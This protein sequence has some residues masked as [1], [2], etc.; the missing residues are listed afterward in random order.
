VTPTNVRPTNPARRFAWAAAWLFVA[1]VSGAALVLL[2]Q[3]VVNFDMYGQ[4]SEGVIATLPVIA[5]AATVVLTV[6]AIR[7]IPAWRRYRSS[8]TV[9]GPAESGLA[10]KG[11]VPFMIAGVVTGLLSVAGVSLLV[12][13]LTTS[14]P[15]A[16]GILLLVAWISLL[17]MATV[18]LLDVALRARRKQRS[19]QAAR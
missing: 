10:P 3:R 2:F 9:V 12:V 11:I 5:V 17:A 16:A 13:L 18:Q 15:K 1:L 4:R 8:V 6:S 7:A 19:A 14:D